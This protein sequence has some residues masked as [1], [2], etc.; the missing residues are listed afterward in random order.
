[1]M[2]KNDL[3]TIEVRRINKMVHSMHRNMENQRQANAEVWWGENFSITV[4]I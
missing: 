3:Q 2:V 4:S 1:M